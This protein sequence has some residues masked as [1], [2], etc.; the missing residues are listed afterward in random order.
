[1]TETYP[2]PNQLQL[3]NIPQSSYT[4]QDDGALAT[5]QAANFIKQWNAVTNIENANRDISLR[6]KQFKNLVVQ[7]DRNYDLRREKQN[8]DI[9]IGDLS[10]ELKKF[11]IRY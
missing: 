8:Q 5:A 7:N 3:P 2:I 11:A 10:F 6:E 1:M 4:I 9:R